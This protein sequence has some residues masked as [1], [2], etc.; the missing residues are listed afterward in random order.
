ML[1]LGI[2]LLMGPR[3]NNAQSTTTTQNTLLWP[4]EQRNEKLNDPQDSPS[5][6]V[7]DYASQP[8][9][10]FI[11][12]MGPPEHSVA[13]WTKESTVDANPPSVEF[14]PGFWERIKSRHESFRAR[15]KSL[16]KSVRARIQSVHESFRARTKRLSESFTTRI[17]SLGE[18]VRARI[19]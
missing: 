12:A 7:D 5:L 1:T 11:I 13:Q 2:Q 19:P 16:G 10:D 14:K 3:R 17:K 18:S 9:G 6:Q 15:I 4:H 8:P